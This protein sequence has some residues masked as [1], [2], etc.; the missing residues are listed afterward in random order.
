MR[1]RLSILLLS[2]SIFACA[3]ASTGIA[4][5]NIPLEGKKIEVL[6]TAETTLHWYVIDAA[7]FSIPIERPPVDDA[8][9]QL[10]AEKGGDALINLR[11]WNDRMI[12]G[13]ITVHRF[14]LQADVVKIVP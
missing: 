6:G 8:V 10:L 11:Y 1:H 2:C 5:S 7:I 4:V 13:P 9:Q 12:F 3:S 14:H